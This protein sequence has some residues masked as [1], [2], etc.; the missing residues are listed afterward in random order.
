MSLQDAPKRVFAQPTQQIV[1]MLLVLIAV[2]IGIFFLS[3][4][5]RTVVTAN[6]YLNAFIGFVF[7]LGVAATFWQVAQVMSSVNW[8]RNLQ[9]G[10][11]GA[12]YI[13]PPSLVASMAPMLPTSQGDAG[14]GA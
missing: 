9:A 12:E 13:Q 10:F 14:T 6:I 2:G 5:I 3:A 8:L 11:K 4:E 1:L 7:V